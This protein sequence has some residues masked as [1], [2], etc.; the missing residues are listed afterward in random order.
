M[1]RIGLF[2][3]TILLGALPL[4]S[5][6]VSIPDA[7]FLN[8][9]IEEGIDSNDDGLISHKEAELLKESTKHTGYFK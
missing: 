3:M 4:Y 9:L 6:I 2:L 1:K 7:A 8:A 5:Q